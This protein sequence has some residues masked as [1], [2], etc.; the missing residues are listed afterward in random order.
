MRLINN[1][2]VI[3]LIGYLH[4]LN[5]PFI[6][7]RSHITAMHYCSVLPGLS[8]RDKKNKQLA[9]AV[10]AHVVFVMAGLYNKQTSVK[11]LFSYWLF[12][13]YIFFKLNVMI[14]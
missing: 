5:I 13:T 7:G 8:Q 11:R 10:T 2:K 4:Q 1:F 14:L 6:Y 12:H 9:V 3:Y